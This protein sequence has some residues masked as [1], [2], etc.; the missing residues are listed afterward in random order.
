MYAETHRLLL[1]PLTREVI[2]TRLA[3][4]T[5]RAAVPTPQGPL[6]VSYPPAWPGDLLPLFPRRLADF[7]P[8]KEAWSATLVERATLT[9][10]GQM[11]AKGTPDAHGDQEIGY[12]LN[13]EVWNQG[14]ATEAVSALVAALLARPDV[15]RVTAQTAITNPASGRVLEKL[16][17]SRV[18]TAWDEEDGDLLVWARGTE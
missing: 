7:N 8:G 16:G 4:D 14:Y 3:R 12:G 5:F 13:P 11:G 18:G 1:V 10:V 15:R 9:A 2:E 17:F 6:T